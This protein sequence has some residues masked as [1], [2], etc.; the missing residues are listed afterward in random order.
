MIRNKIYLI[1]NLLTTGSVLCGFLSIIYS[2]DNNIQIA[3]NLIFAS[4]VLDGLDGRVARIT[5]TTSEFGAQYDS[6]ADVISFGIA[7]AII[8]YQWFLKDINFF[9][10]SWLELGLIIS[11]LYLVSVLLRLAR[12]NSTKSGDFFIG[13]PCPL[14]AV[15][16]CLSYTVLSKTNIEML[17][18]KEISA[19]LVLVVSFLM[20]SKFSYFSFKNIGDSEKIKFYW[21]LFIIFVLFITLIN[22]PMVLLLLAIIYSLSGLVL[23]F[24]RQYKKG[25]LSLAKKSRD[26]MS[27]KKEKLV[28]FDTTL[29]DGEQSPGASM[30]G[31]EK[32]RIAKI[33]EKLNVDVIEA[34]FPIASKGD[35]DAVSDIAKT[36]KGSTICGLARA[37]DKDIDAAGESLKYA[38]SSRIHTFIATSEIHMKKKLNMSKQEVIDQAVSAIKRIKK[39]TN[40][41]EFSPEDAGRSEFDFLCSI[42]EKAINAGATTINIPDTVGYC[43]PGE[44][45]EL[46]KKLINN[47]PNSDKAIFSTHCQ[48]DLGL[49]V[50]NSLSGVMNGAR[51][52]ECTINGLE[53]EQ[54]MPLW[55]KL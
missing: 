50:A 34:G 15:L 18:Y 22:P 23:N 2:F 47:I 26:N 49:A 24:Y 51:Q 19:F 3:A 42:I 55:K 44:Y 37:I 17:F 48:N 8:L 9:I 27:M 10:N 32:L 36:I 33:L 43:I 1:P 53:R 38:E 52:V 40:N 7:P 45:G 4:F 20:I 54:E 39:Y 12:F 46:I 28:I 21:L 25:K 14:A 5:K 6:L 30:T 31:S 41:I 29:R 35:F 13:L 11:S 16:V